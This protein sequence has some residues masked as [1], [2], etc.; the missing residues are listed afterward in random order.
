MPL[1]L[2]RSFLDPLFL[3]I[4]VMLGRYISIISSPNKLLK[5]IGNC[6]VRGTGGRS[7]HYLIGKM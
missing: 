7:G 5:P 2:L 4:L 1:L 3:K 6:Y